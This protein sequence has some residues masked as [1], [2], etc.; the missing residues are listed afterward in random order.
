MARVI[1]KPLEKQTKA[2][3]RRSNVV[4]INAASKIFGFATKTI[5]GYIDEDGLPIVSY[6]KRSKQT[7]LDT[8]V[9]HNW[10]MS[11]EQGGSEAPLFAARL[12]KTQ[13]E[14]L[15]LEIENKA[16]LGTLVNKEDVKQAFAEAIVTLRNSMEGAAGRLAKGKVV[17][18]KKL[19]EEVR[20]IE[21]DYARRLQRKLKQMIGKEGK[22]DED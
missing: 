16:R 20:K 2:R 22:L 7:D 17:V 8:I 14:H 4:S 19:L 1:K 6:N 12:K 21:R 13:E 3:A 5:Q 9:F 15:K 18:R 11:R 10:L